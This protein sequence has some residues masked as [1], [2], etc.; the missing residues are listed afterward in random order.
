MYI[1]ISKTKQNKKNCKKNKNKMV[2]IM[3]LQNVSHQSRFDL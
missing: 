1:T 3:P 2:S